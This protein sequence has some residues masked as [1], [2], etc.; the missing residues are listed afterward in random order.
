MH[1]LTIDSGT[2]SAPTVSTA[3]TTPAPP[4]P[5]C[6]CIDLVAGRLGAV[7]DRY[8]AR[9]SRCIAALEDIRDGSSTTTSG[10]TLSVLFVFA[11]RGVVVAFPRSPACTLSL[12][13]SASAGCARWVSRNHRSRRTSFLV[14]LF[15]APSLAFAVAAAATTSDSPTE[16]S[17]EMPPNA[18]NGT[19][20]THL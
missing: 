19:S 4:T 15:L 2:L 17:L 7:N 8:F 1:T 11:T 14:L 20:P 13:C 10:T 3:P 9:G 6:R 12:R 16:R 18:D 5:A